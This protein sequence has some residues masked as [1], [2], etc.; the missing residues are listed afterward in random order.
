VEAVRKMFAI[1]VVIALSAAACGDSG[2]V[3]ATK[4]AFVGSDN[5]FRGPAKT[6]GGLV[7]FTFS[8]TGTQPHQAQLMRLGGKLNA[9]EA[10]VKIKENKQGGFPE[11]IH[12]A[13]GTQEV[14]AGASEIFTLNLA[15]GQYVW[16]CFVG[17]PAHYTQGM[18]KP[19]DVD[20]GR[21]G[22]LP[23]SA[24]TITAREYAY[25]LPD[26]K[27][28]SVTL[29][30]RNDGPAQPHLFEIVEYP[31]GV[32]LKQVEAFVRAFATG[33]TPK[34]IPDPKPIPGFGAIDP[35]GS[36]T[37]TTTFRPGRVY[38]LL[39]YLTDRGKN[40]PHLSNGMVRSFRVA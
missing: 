2:P 21:K 28:G 12:P 16:L 40:R 39:C 32:T 35:G 23:A 6:K 38:V 19:L 36:A 34:K 24:G 14:G 5:I 26:I 18:A 9:T 37:F 33:G 4:I 29:T 8:N 31:K 30:A 27:A 10:V 25:D 11:G 3:T 1:A 15:E 20:G 22:P 7:E 17:K 13:G